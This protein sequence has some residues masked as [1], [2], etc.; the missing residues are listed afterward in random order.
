MNGVFRFK[1]NSIVHHMLYT[2]G[3]GKSMFF[4]LEEE[5]LSVYPLPSFMCASG[6]RG[7]VQ[8]AG[9]RACRASLQRAPG[10][11]QPSRAQPARHHFCI[12]KKN[13]L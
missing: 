6:A 2:Y 10:A 5:C 9:G 8:L 12:T 1:L 11:T 3:I 13:I 4:T 7:E